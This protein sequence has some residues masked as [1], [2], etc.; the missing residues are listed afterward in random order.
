MKIHYKINNRFIH[1]YF[2]QL[3]VMNENK[4]R[5]ILVQSK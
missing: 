3:K 4:A 2:V 5:F 1:G